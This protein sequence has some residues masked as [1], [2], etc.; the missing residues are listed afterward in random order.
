MRHLITKLN[1]RSPISEQYRTIRTNLQF[2]AVDEELRSMLVTSAGPDEGKSMTAANLAVVYAQ[3]GK[4]VL[5][6]D[7]DLRK[8]TVH[9]KFRLENFKGLS[10][11]LVGETTLENTVAASDV[12]NLDI[13]T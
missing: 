11:V 5:L 4:K 10:N 13:M 1:P 9:Y 12:D 8:P 3:Q 7:A 2:S 6:I